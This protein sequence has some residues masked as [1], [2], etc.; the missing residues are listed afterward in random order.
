MLFF[1]VTLCMERAP[2]AGDD[3]GGNKTYI[4]KKKTVKMVLK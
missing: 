3:V 1:L 2:S 4:K